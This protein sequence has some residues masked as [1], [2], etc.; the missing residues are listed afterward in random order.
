MGCVCVD[1]CGFPK[2]LS[3]CFSAL[4]PKLLSGRSFPN[5]YQEK[6]EVVT[7]IFI[8]A[9]HEMLMEV[10]HSRTEHGSTALEKSVVAVLS[11]AP[12]AILNNLHENL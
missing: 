3:D 11:Q 12:S 10:E 5:F 2:L 1:Q 4:V 9:E 8:N 7:N 6:C